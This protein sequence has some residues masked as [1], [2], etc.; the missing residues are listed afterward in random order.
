MLQRGSNVSP[1]VIPP[2]SINDFIRNH[3]G[4]RGECRNVIAACAT[5][6]YS[7]ALAAS[8]IEQGLCDVVLAGSAEP[9][10]HP[11][12]EA[13]F[14]NMGVLSDEAVMRPFDRRRSGFVFGA[15]A[16]I[17][18]LEAEDHFKRRSGQPQYAVLSGWG[19]GSDT[20]SAVAFN[21]NGQHIADVIG[22][23]LSRAK[24]LSTEVSYVHAHGTAT[25]LNDWI[26]TQAL[27]KAFGPHAGQ[28]MI[29]ATKASTGHMLGAAGSAG[30]IFTVLALKDQFIP[31]TATLEESDPECPLDYTPGRGHAAGF[32]H[33]MALSFGFGGAIGALVVSR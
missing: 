28:L 23:A 13:G 26:E 25:R 2:E 1:I 8:W 17:C 16:G 24:L 14:R 32:E 11:L 22:R 31:P 3:F 4:L 27:M 15:G 20:H 18:V 21:S 19:L 12:M 5:G 33:A 10:P 6:A 9:P 7:I 30:F 29:S